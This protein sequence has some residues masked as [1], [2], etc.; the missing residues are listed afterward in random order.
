MVIGHHPHVVQDI[1]YY[2]DKPIVYSLGNFVFDQYFSKETMQ[3]M[4]YVAEFDNTTLINSFSKT[5][6]LN[7]MY[8]IDS[9]K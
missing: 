7:K 4:L 8:Q 2:K 9:I 5:V 6:Q 3:G 1:G